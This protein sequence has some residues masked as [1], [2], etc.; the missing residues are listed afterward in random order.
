M[1]EVTRVGHSDPSHGWIAVKI[2]EL[3]MLG[4]EASIS[5]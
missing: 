1:A 3:K 5:E 4:I 2:S